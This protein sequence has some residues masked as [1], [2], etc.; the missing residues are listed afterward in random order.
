MKN[1]TV[2]LHHSDAALRV[3]EQFFD[4]HVFRVLRQYSILVS[5]QSLISPIWI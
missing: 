4:G 2:I 5:F 1:S 3:S